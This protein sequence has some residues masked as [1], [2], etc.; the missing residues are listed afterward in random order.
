LR[1]TFAAGFGVVLPGA[2]GDAGATRVVV[3]RAGFGSMVASRSVATDPV[4]MASSSEGRR[5]GT[6]RF[7]VFFDFVLGLFSWNPSGIGGRSF[8]GGRLFEQSQHCSMFA[9]S[10]NAGRCR[11]QLQCSYSFQ[12]TFVRRDRFLSGVDDILPLFDADVG[13]Q[14][15]SETAEKMVPE[16]KI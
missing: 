10:T 4:S 11:P 9:G 7:G 14:R 16:P 15:I 13:P 12:Y 8:M 2:G 5:L 3:R 1:A 6:I